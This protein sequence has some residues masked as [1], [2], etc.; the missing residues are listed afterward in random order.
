MVALAST[1]CSAKA[2]TFPTLG[3]V[4]PE[5]ALPVFAVGPPLEDHDVPL[6][7]VASL[8]A[9]RGR[10]V[11][12]EFWA[13]W[14]H[15]CLEMHPEIARLAEQYKDRGVVTYGIVYADAT[16][17]ALAWL[18]GHGG[19]RYVELRDDDGAVAHAYGVHAIPQ[20]FLVG[21]NGRLLSHC[22]GCAN[23]AEDFGRIIDSVVTT[24][25]HPRARGHAPE[26]PER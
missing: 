24:K 7:R 11:I 6:G 26:S 5:F 10:I 21:P 23:V 2:L 20:M 13:T 4:A 1:R 15:P 14:C 9:N 25:T 12:L 16:S 18:R 19:V 8:R 22:W 3:S 17:T